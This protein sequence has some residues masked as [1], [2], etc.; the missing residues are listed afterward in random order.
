MFCSVKDTLKTMIRGA[1]DWEE[2]FEILT[3]D[4]GLESSICKEFSQ[5]NSKKIKIPL[6]NGQKT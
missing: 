3:P 1:I 6:K 2:I 4:K 5:L